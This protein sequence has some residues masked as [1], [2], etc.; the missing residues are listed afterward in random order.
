[1]GY[2]WDPTKN[3]ANIAIRGIDFADAVRIFDGP[4]LEKADDRYDYGEARTS[5]VGVMDG[6][7]VVV[8][9]TERGENRTIISARKA[10]SYERKA[11]HKAYS[12]LAPPR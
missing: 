8:V 11:Y 4:T 3:R 7:E 5:A 12:H 9:Y 2:E 6:R 10:T 1:M